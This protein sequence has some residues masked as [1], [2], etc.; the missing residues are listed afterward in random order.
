MSGR[1]CCRR[2]VSTFHAWPIWATAASRSASPCTGR[3]AQ[4][5]ESN[6]ST[7]PMHG[8]YAPSSVGTTERMCATVAGERKSRAIQMLGASL[9]RSAASTAGRARSAASPPVNEREAERAESMS[10]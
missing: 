2:E 6:S 7:C 8:R 4:R 10:P 1:P 3:K 9:S 5:F